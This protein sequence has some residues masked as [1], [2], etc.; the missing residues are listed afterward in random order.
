MIIKK[1]YKYVDDI[2]MFLD[3]K[4]TNT[5]FFYVFCLIILIYKMYNITKM[6]HV[7]IVLLQHQFN[8]IVIMARKC[9]KDT[10]WWMHFKNVICLMI[11]NHYCLFVHVKRTCLCIVAILMYHHV[12][13]YSCVIFMHWLIV[14]STIKRYDYATITKWNK[15]VVNPFVH[16][17]DIKK[18]I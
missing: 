10:N 16:Y 1:I 8:L 18:N 9:L 3:K 17:V 14:H 5:I 12:K 11:N 2:M 7:Y 15:K 4:I 6:A 13:Y